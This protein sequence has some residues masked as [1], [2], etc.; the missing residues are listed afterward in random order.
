MDGSSLTLEERVATYQ[1]R[2]GRHCLK[3]LGAGV[4][5]SVYLTARATEGNPLAVKFHDRDAGYTRER[6]AYHRLRYHHVT[7]VMG[8]YVPQFIDH[9]DD[10]LAIEMTVV[11]RPFLLDFGGAYLDRPPDYPKHVLRRWRAE[12]RWQFGKRWPDVESILT[13]LEAYGIYLA[14]V[15][16]GNITFGD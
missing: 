6:D 4:Q 7:E 8:H 11:R 1:S 13:E 14:D 10:L 2:T 5:G 16:P 12:K 9:Y 3:R 15:N